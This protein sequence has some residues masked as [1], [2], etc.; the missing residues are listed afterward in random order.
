MIVIG[1][2]D[3]DGNVIWIG[4]LIG[5]VGLEVGCGSSVNYGILG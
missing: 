3:L 5:I 4:W 2:G 1:K